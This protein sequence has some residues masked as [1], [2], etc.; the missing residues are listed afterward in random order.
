MTTQEIIA[1]LEE[2]KKDKPTFDKT[3]IWE[4]IFA[5]EKELAKR[6]EYAALNYGRQPDD[7]R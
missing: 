3:E 6:G 4:E 1:R 7:W 2:L 5:L